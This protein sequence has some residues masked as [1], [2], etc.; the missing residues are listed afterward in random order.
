MSSVLNNDLFEAFAN[1]S[2]KIYIYVT[3]M[4]TGVTRWSKAAVEY[5]P[6]IEEYMENVGELWIKS[7]H[8]EDRE[9]YL[10]DISAVLDG[11]SSNHNCQYRAINRYGNYVWVECKGSVIFDADGN[12]DVFAGIMTRLDNYNKYDP[13]TH[14]LTSYELVRN[15]VAGDGSLM[16][17]GIDGFRKIN[18]EH[19]FT[20][21]NEI[22]IYIAELLQSKAEGAKV[23]RFVGDEFVICGQDMT[24]SQMETIFEAVKKECA[25]VDKENGIVDFS[26]TAGIIEFHSEEETIDIIAKSEV[27]YNYAKE[28][29]VGSY[30]IYS[31]EIE[32]KIN[33]G[34]LISETLLA[35]IKSDFKGFRLVYQPIIDNTGDTVIA[36]EALLRWKTDNEQ[37][38]NCYPDEFISIL[39]RN[40]GMTAVG[41]F[42]MRESIRQAAEWQKLY[43]DFNVSFN[44]SYVQLE[45]ENFAPSVIEAIDKYGADP[46]HIVVELTESIL[47]VDTM[48]VKQSF[49]ILRDRGIMIALDD[50]GT[51]NSSFWMLHNIDVDI[52]KLDQSFIRKLDAKDTGIDRAIVESVGIMCNRIGCKTVAEGIETEEIWKM[53]SEY[54]FT[55]LQGYLFSKPIEVSEFEELLAKYNM[56]K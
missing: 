14:L 12:P 22:L 23:Y 40:G 16:V 33:R 35:S 1:A 17:I 6:D 52:V 31:E 34:K 5:F 18:S 26:I 44:V 42:V 46:K 38:G 3:D 39:E 48:K 54:G 4:K 19:G 13:I 7:V 45:D 43:K 30:T 37:I 15:G 8:P 25:S 56:Q 29:S 49:Q 28:N 32:N 2:D 11:T 27:C 51:G 53:V 50:F 10:K 9:I 20:Y 24:I 47:N 36:C 21:A 41:Y 55:G